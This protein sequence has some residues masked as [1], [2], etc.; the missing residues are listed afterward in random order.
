VKVVGMS[1]VVV[2]LPDV[3]LNAAQIESSSTRALPM[4]EKTYLCIINIFQ[5][6]VMNYS[7]GLSYTIE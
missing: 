3:V 5:N 2:A 7:I 4:M 1:A 6:K